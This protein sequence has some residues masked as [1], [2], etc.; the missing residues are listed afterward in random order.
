MAEPEAATTTTTPPPTTEGTTITEA[1]LALDK[2]GRIS[3]Q[4]RLNLLGYDTRGVDGVFGPGTRAG[5][6][7]WQ[8]KNGMPATGYLAA[9]QLAVLNTTSEALYVSWLENNANTATTT[10]TTKS[11]TVKKKKRRVYRGRDG[12]LRTRP[13]NAR[14]WIIRG[15]SRYCNRRRA[16]RI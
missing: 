7:Q 8:Y 13:G 9:D 14:R 4:R 2:A 5:I 3:V 11:K 16:G 6:T 12:C 10:T 15:Q 1:A